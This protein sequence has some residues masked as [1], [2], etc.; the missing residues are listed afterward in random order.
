MTLPTD[1]TIEPGVLPGLLRD[2]YLQRG[3]GLLHF[4]R[5]AD[6]GSVCFIRGHIAW[7]QSSL[8]ECRLGS[9]LVRHGLV[10]PESIEQAY[11][12]VG[13]GKRLGDVL[14]EAGGIDRERLD[15]ALALQVR[16]T[17]L[18][19]FGW[20]DGGWRF[21]EHDPQHFKGYDQAL[22][23]ST[24]DLIMDAVWCVADP[25]VVVYALGDLDR[26]LALTTDPLLRF[27]RVTLTQMDRLL[28][29]QADG[30]RSAQEV[31]ALVP[32]DA[33]EAQRSL[34]GLLCVGLL[35]L[36]D[37]PE[38]PEPPEAD[39]PPTR[40]EVV[41]MHREMAAKD[42]FEVL[43]ITRAASVDDARAAFVRLAR[44]FH[45]DAQSVPELAGL[46][47]QIEEIFARLA[48]ADRVLTVPPRRAEYE[49]RLVLSDVQTL[50]RIE[51]DPVP[52]LPSE[53]DPA[54]QAASRE[55]AL[56]AA[57]HAFAEARYWDALQAMDQLL[58]ELEGRQRRRGALLRARALA[59]NPKWRKDAEDQLKAI[60]EADPGS[61]DALFELG[62]LYKSGGMDARAAATFRQVL[63][64]RPRH[65]GALGELEG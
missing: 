39:L 47:T 32:D 4:T 33:L 29:S 17:L 14:L 46:R 48:D 7:G 56:V 53:A 38:P 43:G 42:H 60:V 65:A 44:R 24:G 15:Q 28:V 35:E 8:E 10:S 41:R 2:L 11:E 30:L 13:G 34:F 62:R 9:V 16:E 31:L 51:P 50:L 49:R 12:L 20:V 27:Q 37:L 6:R 54:A 59:Q 45:P 52:S 18:N 22:G 36:V 63:K 21:E 55:E 40:D 23:V 57:E 61:V 64:L 26:P 3:T 5:G 25:D 1:W 58:P 19:V